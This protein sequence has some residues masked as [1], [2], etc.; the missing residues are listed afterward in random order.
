[1]IRRLHVSVVV[2][3]F[4][5]AEDTLRC[6]ESI[7]KSDYPD[8]D[9]VVVDN[10]SASVVVRNLVSELDPT[11]RIILNETNL[12]YAGGNNVGI[13]HALERDSAFVWLVNPDVVVDQDAL[14]ILVRTAQRYPNAGI[15][16]SRILYG[17]VQP[18]KI[19]FDG[20][21]IDWTA[22]G[23][24]KHLRM[25]A[26]E[27]ESPPIPAYDVD[28]VTGAGMLLSRRIIANIGLLPEEWFLYFEETDYNLRA[29]RAGWRT[30]VNPRS[31][32]QH[33]KRSTGA[34]P[35]PYYVYYFTR[36]R[37]RFGVIRAGASEDQVRTQLEAFVE[38]WR[39]KVE[40]NAPEWLS[41]YDRLVKEAIWD[42][43]SGV[44]GYR[45]L[46]EFSMVAA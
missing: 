43:L 19:W 9:I 23:A 38:A 3:N 15:L 11:I 36:N 46:S 33:Y 28:Y 44:T 37:V 45:D 17:G 35:Q 27:S 31:R 4:M 42:G 5:H 18:S 24:T 7:Q 25:G 30:M 12:G 21:T 1:M 39:K 10:G 40:S 2:L 16:G 32:L 8:L 13:R 41:I 20:G 14:K 6:V 34:L 22:A 26:L 29:Q